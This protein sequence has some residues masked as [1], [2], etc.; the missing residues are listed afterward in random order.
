MDME[1]L[2]AY[3]KHKRI[4]KQQCIQEND[5]LRKCIIC[6]YFLPSQQWASIMENYV[7]ERLG[8]LPPLD[9]TSGDA[10]TPQGHTIE[11]KIS[12]GSDKGKFN[13]VQLRP[14]HKVDYYF[15]ML[16]NMYDGNMGRVYYILLS[17]EKVCD[18][19]VRYGNYA[20]GTVSR[21]GYITVESIF[22]EG[23]EYALRPNPIAR[24]T[25]KARQLWVELL[26]HQV[27]LVPTIF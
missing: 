4:Y 2:V 26:D 22:T 18:L 24:K 25:S 13:L 7:R 14:C 5:P 1:S 27:E 23:R 16:Y 10:T 8:L 3:M 6:K 9:N 21:L 15:F 11:I 19:I 17:S 20:H 12:L